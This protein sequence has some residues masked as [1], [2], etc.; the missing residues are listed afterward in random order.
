MKPTVKLVVLPRA[1]CVHHHFVLEGW[2]ESCGRAEDLSVENGG[3]ER[4]LILEAKP[5]PG[6]EP[7]QEHGSAHV[8]KLEL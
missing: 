8:L 5:M 7:D 6:P 3:M 2:L 4:K 1:R